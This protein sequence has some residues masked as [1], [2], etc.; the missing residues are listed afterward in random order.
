MDEPQIRAT[1]SEDRSRAWTALTLFEGSQRELLLD[2][3]RYWQEAAMESIAQAEASQGLD[4]AD[5]LTGTL[6]DKHAR[7]DIVTKAIR[8]VEGA[9][10]SETPTL[11]GPAWFVQEI[12][13]GCIGLA[14]ERLGQAIEA[15]CEEQGA[16]SRAEVQQALYRVRLWTRT[17]L[18]ALTESR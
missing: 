13:R 12:I 7:L 9:G 18:A 5:E 1:A 10:T 14:A 3:L 6:A 16:A 8:E 17:L 15:S 2:E 11:A 4:S